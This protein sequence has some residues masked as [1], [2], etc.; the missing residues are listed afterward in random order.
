MPALVCLSQKKYLKYFIPVS[1][2][3]KM[4]LCNKENDTKPVS[5][6]IKLTYGQ[7]ILLDEVD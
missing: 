7:Q 5:I 2:D 6:A 1:L 3:Y 4:D